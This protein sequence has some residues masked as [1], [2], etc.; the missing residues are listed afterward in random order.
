MTEAVPNNPPE[1]LRVRVF[2][3]SFHTVDGTVRLYEPMLTNSGL[4]QV[5]RRCCS[6]PTHATRH[7][8]ALLCWH[9]TPVYT[10]RVFL[11]LLLQLR[12]Q[13]PFAR[14]HVPMNPETGRPYVPADMTIGAALSIYGRRFTVT[15]A[16]AHT[17]ALLSA[18]YGV[19]LGE[20]LAPPTPPVGGSVLVPPHAPRSNTVAFD[21]R[22]E[23]DPDRG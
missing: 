19:H 2:Q 18:K 5:R 11:P 22:K 3:L 23:E 20:P 10:K 17:R 13:G 1:P 12:L 7:F 8:A 6:S 15:D 4:L 21:V 16:D 14:R 9:S